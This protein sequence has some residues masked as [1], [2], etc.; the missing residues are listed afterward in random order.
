MANTVDHRPV[1]GLLAG[2]EP[3]GGQRKEG[4][5]D[6]AAMRMRNYHAKR[7]SQFRSFLT[8]DEPFNSDP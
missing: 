6:S 4:D 8:G 3:G 2:G 5:K 7:R 1:D